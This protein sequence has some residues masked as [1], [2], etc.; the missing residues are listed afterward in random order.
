[1]RERE[2]DGNSAYTFYSE[3]GKRQNVHN[4]LLHLDR[5]DRDECEVGSWHHR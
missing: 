1:M 3:G 2:R 4:I 5:G